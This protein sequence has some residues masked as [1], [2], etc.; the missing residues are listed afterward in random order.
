M[1]GERSGMTKVSE[2][3]LLS[4][5][6]LQARLSALTGIPARLITR[7]MQMAVA[8]IAAENDTDEHL[9]DYLDGYRRGDPQQ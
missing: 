2:R 9:R 3:V 8:L 6:Q 5:D 4:A 7:D 1:A